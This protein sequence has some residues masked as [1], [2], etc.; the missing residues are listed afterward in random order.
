MVRINEELPIR[1]VL[2]HANRTILSDH[3]VDGFAGVIVETTSG[4]PLFP[5]RNQLEGTLIYFPGLSASDL[6]EGNI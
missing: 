3:I 1:D 4:D 5:E 2:E 6:M